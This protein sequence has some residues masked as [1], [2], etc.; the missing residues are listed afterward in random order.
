MPISKTIHN[1]LYTVTSGVLVNFDRTKIGIPKSEIRPNGGLKTTAV[2]MGPNSELPGVIEEV[3]TV[4]PKG[5]RTTFNLWLKTAATIEDSETDAVLA[6]DRVDVGLTVSVPGV[7]GIYDEV[8]VQKALYAIF[9]LTYTAVDGS[10]NLP[11]TVLNKWAHH[12]TSL[13]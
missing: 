11:T 4:D 3:I 13:G 5:N 7:V 1:L 9:A 12:E 2:V 10:G 8:M 6:R